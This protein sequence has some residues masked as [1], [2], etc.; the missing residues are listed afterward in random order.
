MFFIGIF[1]INTK[2][3]EI[4]TENSIICPIC[5]AYGRYEIIKRYTYFHFFFIPLWRWNRQYF[6][7]TRCCNRICKLDT[8]IGI[9]LERGE[10]ISIGKE[11]LQCEDI[12]FR[13]FV[14]VVP[15]L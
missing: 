11:D 7:K 14:L 12:T 8:E 2:E 1:G 4:K 3:E 6:I 5:E 13:R 10:S 15:Y 9:R